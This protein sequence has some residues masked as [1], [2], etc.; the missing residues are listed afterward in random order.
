MKFY[1]NFEAKTRTKKSYRTKEKP[2]DW[3]PVIAVVCESFWTTTHVTAMTSKASEQTD[4]K[5]CLRKM[6]WPLNAY[7]LSI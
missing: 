2:L 1:F 3:H 7:N 4:W 5:T 6:W